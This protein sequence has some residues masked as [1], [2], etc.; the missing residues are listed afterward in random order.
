[1]RCQVCGAQ[2]EAVVTTL[3]FKVRD[4]TIIIIKG[5]PVRQCA[6]CSEYLLEDAV[7]AQVDSILA[8]ANAAAEL[9]V[10]EFAA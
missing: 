3:P 2:M 7:M 1:M 8:H 4:R 5:V 9:E 6:R 10:I